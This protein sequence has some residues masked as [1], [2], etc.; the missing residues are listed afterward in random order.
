[1]PSVTSFSLG[2]VGLLL[3]LLLVGMSVGACWFFSRDV[4]D[5]WHRRQMRREQ[6]RLL[7]V[8]GTIRK[9]R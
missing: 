4:R 7:F 5:W 6:L 9:L 1:M 2:T 8:L 3:Q